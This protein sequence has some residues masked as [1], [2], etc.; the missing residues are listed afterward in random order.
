MPHKTFGQIIAEQA[1]AYPLMQ[2]Q[3]LVKLA[4][5][6]AL[7]PGHMISD[8][9]ITLTRLNH[10][11]SQLPDEPA[12]GLEPVGNGLVRFHLGALAKSGLTAKTLNR[13]FVLTANRHKQDQEL[14]WVYLDQLRAAVQAGLP[15][16]SPLTSEDLASYLADYAQRGWPA[17]SHSE[18][19]R[20]AYQPAY[21][22]IEEEFIPFLPLYGAIDSQLAQ[23]EK[24]IVALDGNSGSGKSTLAK[25]IQAV[26]GGNLFQMDDFFLTPELR[27]PGRLAENG[28]NIDYDRFAAEVLAGLASGQPFSY[29]SYDCQTAAFSQPVL[30]TPQQ[31]NLVEGV[32]SLHPRFISHYSLKVLLRISR[33]K[34]KERILARSGPA[35]YQR[36]LK[37]WIPLEDR[38][39]AMI[40]E[41]TL[42]LVFDI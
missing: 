39:Y 20:Q 23:R 2:C 35:L 12:A 31:F 42:D 30:V 40:K 28:G 25:T 38:F 11:I 21:R 33:Q 37:E 5:Q 6:A 7:G 16:S 17:L 15:L 22:V 9:G 4:Y 32:Y 29:R 13:F 27:S 26:Y 1:A 18:I 8:E 41:E 14:F 34:Q 36:F 10:E 24:V 3:D 19:Y